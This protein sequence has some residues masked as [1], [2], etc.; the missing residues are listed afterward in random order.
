M[1]EPSPSRPDRQ[2][3]DLAQHTAILIVS[4]NGRDFLRDCLQSV[5]ASPDAPPR[6]HIV[7]VDNASTDGTLYMLREE[8]AGVT[9]IPLRQNHGFAG[10]NNVG[11]HHVRTQLAQV[12]YVA[13]LNQ[14]T[15]VRPGWLAALCRM[16]EQHP[17]AASIQS[18]LLLHPET[19]LLNSAGNASHYLGFG[20]V[21]GYRE[22]DC[23]QYDQVR[24][25]AFCS[26]AAMCVRV[27]AI[28]PQGLF[29]SEY[30][31]YL[32]DAELGWRLRLAGHKNLFCPDSVVLHRYAFN[33]NPQTYYRLERNRWRLLLTCYRRRTLLLLLPMLIAMEVGLLYYFRR[34]GALRE[35]LRSWDILRERPLLIS[36]RQRIQALR[37]ISDRDLTRPFIAAVHFPEVSNWLLT[38]LGNPLLS[39]YWRCARLLL[40]W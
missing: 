2:P 30:L 27:A 37:K 16:A 28:G 10:G 4:Y 12:R 29:E 25:L 40:W 31:N 36:Q 24:E 13:L 26:G 38:T 20:F 9:V 1:T 21:T 7:V 5:L 17:E 22:Q 8:F 14:D 3:G 39:L 35:K 18:K 15:I 19:T 6:S 32:E 34:A 11:F 23:G 33:R